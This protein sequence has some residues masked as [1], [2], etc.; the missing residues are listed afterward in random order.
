MLVQ[1]KKPTHKKKEVGLWAE[2]DLT[3]AER[4]DMLLAVEEVLD[5]QEI[6]FSDKTNRTGLAVQVLTRLQK[7]DVTWA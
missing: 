5:E 2:C 3:K 4:Y 6:L 7:R 1:G